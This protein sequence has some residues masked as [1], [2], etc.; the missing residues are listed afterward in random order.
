M[1]VAFDGAFTKIQL[2]QK[3]KNQFYT[4]FY[5]LLHDQNCYVASTMSER[6]RECLCNYVNKQNLNIIAMINSVNASSLLKFRLNN[7]MYSVNE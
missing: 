3:I 5:E 1:E 6:F 7:F 2:I 4:P